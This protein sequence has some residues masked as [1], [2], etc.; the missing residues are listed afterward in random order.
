M[1]GGGLLLGTLI[2]SCLLSK[3]VL[4]SAWPFELLRLL[5]FSDV[6][7]SRDRRYNETPPAV[8]ERET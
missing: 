3:K 1:D 7:S 5:D 2:T 6:Y 8:G 4:I